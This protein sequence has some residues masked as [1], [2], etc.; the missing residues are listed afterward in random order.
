MEKVL[1]IEEQK[2]DLRR[3]QATLMEAEAA[4]LTA[5]QKCSDASSAFVD[6]VRDMELSVIHPRVRSLL[7]RIPQLI[8]KAAD[9]P[10]ELSDCH[11]IAQGIIKNNDDVL[12]MGGIP[13][14]ESPV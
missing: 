3:H 11:T 2:I 7:K 12:M 1:R 5:L 4:S 13:K 6:F 8:S 14:S 9:V 10:T